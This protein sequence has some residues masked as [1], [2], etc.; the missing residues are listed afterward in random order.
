VKI[1][2]SWSQGIK[3][4]HLEDKGVDQKIILKWNFYK[5]GGDHV[6]VVQDKDQLWAL[7]NMTLNL[8][9]H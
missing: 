8:G 2:T 6:P 5:Y 1:Y 4:I 3:D 9:F 7:V